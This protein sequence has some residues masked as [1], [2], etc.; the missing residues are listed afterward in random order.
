[1]KQA[2]N[3]TNYKV[4]TSKACYTP[5]NEIWGNTMGGKDDNTIRIVMENINN[6]LSNKDHNLKLDNG[7]KWLLENNVDVACWIETGV[8][9]HQ[10][11]FQERLLELMRED[12]WDNQI[13]IT[14]NNIHDKCGKRQFGGTATMLFNHVAST[15]NGSGS[16][17]SGLG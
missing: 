17:S 6:I 16:D 8:P 3:P 13:T 5:D 1:M 9:W 4:S 7:K 11:H 15:M 10:R 12:S 2:Y 14:S